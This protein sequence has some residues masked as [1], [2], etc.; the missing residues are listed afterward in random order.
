MIW[1][2]AMYG[3][4]VR[5]IKKRAEDLVAGPELAHALGG[6]VVAVLDERK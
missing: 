4:N 6:H 1:H 5:Q 2:A 3:I